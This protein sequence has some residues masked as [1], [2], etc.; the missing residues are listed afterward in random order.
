MAVLQLVY[1]QLLG[2]IFLFFLLST[3]ELPYLKTLRAS[4]VAIH[5]RTRGRGIP[6]LLLYTN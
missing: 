4:A 6:L 1:D 5:T 3:I 2:F